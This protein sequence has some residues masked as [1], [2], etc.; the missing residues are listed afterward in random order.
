MKATGKTMSTENLIGSRNFHQ[1]KFTSAAIQIQK[2]FRGYMERK[3]LSDVLCRFEKLG[4]FDL[5][6]EDRM[7]YSFSINCETVTDTAS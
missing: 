2:Y 6:L 5:Q 7:I 4:A 1:H 3:S